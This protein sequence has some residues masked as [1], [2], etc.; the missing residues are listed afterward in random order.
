MGISVRMTNS[1]AFLT[2]TFSGTTQPSIFEVTA[3]QSL[4][5]TLGP[6]FRHIIKVVAT[7]QPQHCGFLLKL[8]DELLLLANS[9][10]QLHY[11]KVYNASFTENFYGLERVSTNGSRLDLNPSYLSLILLPYIS[12]KLETYFLKSREDQADGVSPT[13][14][15]VLKFRELF[16]TLYPSLHFLVDTVN[17]GF[18]L[19]FTLRKGKHHSLLSWLLG[20]CLVYVTPDGQKLKEGRQ[21]KAI[22]GSQGLRHLAISSMS[23]AARVLTFS[24]EVGSFF[25]QFLDWWYAH[26]GGS[27]PGKDLETNLLIPAPPP[28]V[29][30]IGLGGGVCP[31]CYKKRRGDTVL[32]SSGLV[33]CYTCIVQYLRREAKCPVTRI[34]ATEENLVRIFP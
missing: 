25:L 28:P 26:G 15:L 29:T 22:K 11:L 9:A 2:S 4:A 7:N 27:G 17:I 6:A 12:R 33:F 20:L 13:N 1:G 24:L 3:Q 30:D 23:T 16:V 10:L 8:Q 18:L 32:Q 14:Q 21:L 31:L 19:S 34:P 5:D